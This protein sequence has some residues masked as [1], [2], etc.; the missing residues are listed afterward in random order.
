M[1]TERQPTSAIP[2]VSEIVGLLRLGQRSSVEARVVRQ[3]L[4]ALM[5]EG[6]I[7]FSHNDGLFHFTGRDAGSNAIAYE[8]QGV[9]AHGFGL[10]RLGPDAIRRRSR[11]G[12]LTDAS[13]QAVLA[14]IVAPLDDAGRLVQFA[15]ELEQTLLKDLQAQ[16]QPILATLSSRN[17]YDALEGDMMDAHPAHP[18]YKSR[19]G[20]SLADNRR[21]GP[22]FKAAIIPEWLA[23]R[24][25][26][27][28]AAWSH[29]I[30]GCSLIAGELGASAID[31]FAER[32][33]ERG[34]SWEEVVAIPVHPW[35]WRERVSALVAPELAAGDVVWL[36]RGL[37]RY[38][39]QQSIRTLANADVP[40]AHA[41][42]LSLGI[43]NTS[44]S[45]ILARHT[46]LNAPR[47]TDWL[48]R[49][50]AE[51]G[52]PGLTLLGEVGGASLDHERLGSLRAPR[53]YGQ[54]G[55]IWRESI[56]T[57]LVP[58]EAAIPFNALSHIQRDGTPLIADWVQSHGIESWTLRMLN[59][60]VRPIIHFLFGYGIGLEAHAQ[61]VILIHREGSPERI[62]LKDFHDGVRFVPRLL[63]R[64]DLAPDLVP[65]PASHAA[66]NSNS[67]LVA[68][69]ADQVRDYSADSVLFVALG[70]LGLFLHRHFGFPE[71]RFWQGVAGVIEAWRGEHPEHAGRG[72]IF[73]L[74]VPTF[75]V[76]ALTRRRLFGDAEAQIMHV[77][78]PLAGLVRC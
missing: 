64:P 61:N 72:R 50:I 41:L 56:H 36:G 3:L 73:D 53:A 74:G 69:T 57:H 66:I 24:T 15:E 39:A 70:E 65:V 33:A 13:L 42:K 12:V 46:V 29:G 52:V 60:V 27:A 26:H 51:D 47:I 78:N 76:E 67:F 9:V 49:L 31:I 18:C 62:A 22:E 37:D 1:L 30:D 10:I 20:F 75:E 17:D 43:L 21:Y 59:A 7:P 34:L 55:A 68:E 25:S 23:V 2:D 16:A 5:F 58:G 6:V 48:R 8:A 11:D 44:T 63:A 19:I 14:E 4:Q 54:L 32:L 77:A 71:Q 40:H 38:C 35:Q 45:R 28:S